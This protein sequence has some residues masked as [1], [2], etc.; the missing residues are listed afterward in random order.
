MRAKP[1]VGAPTDGVRRERTQQRCAAPPPT[2]STCFRALRTGSFPFGDERPLKAGEAGVLAEKRYTS[3]LLRGPQ[4]HARPRAPRTV[5]AEVK[6][7]TKIPTVCARAHLSV[8]K[9]TSQ[10]CGSTL[11][12]LMCLIGVQAVSSDSHTGWKSAGRRA[13]R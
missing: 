8:L 10:K 12:R 7:L 4:E 11:C 3:F 5:S 2:E 6:S 1:D 9:K 13:A